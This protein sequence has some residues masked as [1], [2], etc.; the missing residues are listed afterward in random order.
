MGSSASKPASRAANAATKATRQYPSRP[1]PATST[2]APSTARTSNAPSQPPPPPAANRQPG[3]TV[4]PQA[5]ASGQR[6]EGKASRLLPCRLH[7]RTETDRSVL[8]RNQPRCFRSRLCA[9]AASTRRSTTE[10][11]TL[12]F[13]NFCRTP[14][15]SLP[16]PLRTTR[17]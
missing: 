1:S 10:S 11:Y 13:V 6:N 14:E 5:R 8:N 17:E 7:Q 2:Q 9:L 15:L 3:P 16:K 4:H 12:A